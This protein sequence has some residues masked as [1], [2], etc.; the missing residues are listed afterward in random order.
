MWYGSCLYF[1]SFESPLWLALLVVDVLCCDGAGIVVR[2]DV[3]TAASLVAMV[4]IL[5]VVVE[6]V[7][8][9]VQEVVMRVDRDEKESQHSVTSLW[10]RKCTI[11]RTCTRKQQVGRLA[12]FPLCAPVL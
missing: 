5:V 9:A 1:L 3:V 6:V 7:V 4:A 12:L 10:A 11:Q 2:E 8:M